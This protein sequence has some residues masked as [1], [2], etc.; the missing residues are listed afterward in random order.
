MT[1][2]ETVFG[3]KHGPGF[4]AEKLGLLT[5]GAATRGAHSSPR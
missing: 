5:A 2:T 1:M 3:L 4:G